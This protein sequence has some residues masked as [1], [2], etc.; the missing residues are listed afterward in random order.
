[1]CKCPFKIEFIDKINNKNE[2]GGEFELYDCS[3]CSMG[4]KLLGVSVTD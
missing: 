2:V 3:L 4:I 1:M